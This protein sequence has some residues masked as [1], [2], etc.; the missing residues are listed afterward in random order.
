M[1]TTA[2]RGQVSKYLTLSE[3]FPIL[4]IYIPNVINFGIYYAKWDLCPFNKEANISY[5]ITTVL[6]KR[7]GEKMVIETKK[8]YS[9]IID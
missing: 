4:P 1:D 8:S 9:I 6:S 7:K 2:G 3:T 5:Q